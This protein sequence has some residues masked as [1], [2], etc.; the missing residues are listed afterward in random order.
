MKNMWTSHLTYVVVFR[1]QQ[2]TEFGQKLRPVLQLSF[3]GNGGDEDS[4]SG[5]I[6]QFDSAHMNAQISHQRPQAYT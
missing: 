4:C 1:I 2:Q 6:A 5:E 3:G